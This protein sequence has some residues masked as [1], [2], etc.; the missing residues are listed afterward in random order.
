M[1]RQTLERL[2]ID[3]AA[4]AL[5]DDVE[6]LLAAYLAGDAEAAK[7]ASGWRDVADLA[8]RAMAVSEQVVLPR[9]RTGHMGVGWRSRRTSVFALG[10]AVA[11]AACILLGVVLGR[12]VFVASRD[13]APS[14]PVAVAPAGNDAVKAPAVAATADEGFWSIRKAMAQPAASVRMGPVLVWHSPVKEPV[15]EGDGL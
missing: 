3:R 7:A 15:L 2:L 10:G 1:E 13:T 14:R 6:Q 9:L 12:S 8:R 11:A 5:D 4:G